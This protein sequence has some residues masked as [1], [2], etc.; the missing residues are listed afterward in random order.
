M[1]TRRRAG[2]QLQDL[3]MMHNIRSSEDL[4]RRNGTF[5]AHATRERR[6]EEILH[7]RIT[8]IRVYG[9]QEDVMAANIALGGNN[10]AVLGGYNFT[11]VR[12]E[13]SRPRRGVAEL[14]DAEA[15][16]SYALTSAVL[17]RVLAVTDKLQRAIN[18]FSH[19]KRVMKDAATK[20]VDEIQ[21]PRGR[22]SEAREMRAKVICEMPH[23]VFGVAENGELNIVLP[24]R[25]GDPSNPIAHPLLDYLEVQ[26]G[27]PISHLN[28]ADVFN[29]HERANHETGRRQIHLPETIRGRIVELSKVAGE[30]SRIREE[31][32]EALIVIALQHQEYRSSIEAEVDRGKSGYFGLVTGCYDARDMKGFGS[33]IRTITG[34]GA[35]PTRKDMR[36]IIVELSENKEMQVASIAGFHEG[37]KQTCGAIGAYMA[38]N[39]EHAESRDGGR[40]H[41]QEHYT[42]SVADFAESIPRSTVLEGK[43]NAQVARVFAIL[44]GKR[45]FL[46]VLYKTANNAEGDEKERRAAKDVLQRVVSGQLSVITVGVDTTVADRANKIIRPTEEDA[47]LAEEVWKAWG[48]DQRKQFLNR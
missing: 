28:S 29:A 31:A 46:D 33:T 16:L 45:K 6:Y 11:I 42:D 47:H 32:Y 38:V 21:R 34:L 41:L 17:P 26:L 3:L 23:F 27:H 5:E 18:Q 12:P 24:D 35:M 1:P 7:R 2:D 40:H 39:H 36:Q 13:H 4:L 48:A 37:E 20:V 30:R 15:G 14:G 9:A 22:K 10:R 8:T 19:Y 43:T 44:S 25:F